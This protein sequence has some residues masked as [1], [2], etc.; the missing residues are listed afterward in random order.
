MHDL[1]PIT[2]SLLALCLLLCLMAGT[3]THADNL[4]LNGDDLHTPDALAYRVDESGTLTIEDIMR[5]PTSAFTPQPDHRLPS[6]RPVWYRL[7][8]PDNSGP[9]QNLYLDLGSFHFN[10]ATLFYVEDGQLVRQQTGLDITSPYG[11]DENSIYLSPAPLYHAAPFGFCMRTL[12]L[13]GTVVM[14]ERFDPVKALSCIDTYGVTH[15][16]WVPTMFVRM[17]KLDPAER[18]AFD[19]SSHR[20][21]MHAAAPCPVAV[22]QQML[23]WGGPIIWE[24]YAGTERNGSTLIGPEEWLAHPG[25]V[26]QAQPPFEALIIGDDGNELPPGQE[27]RLYFHDTTGRGIIYAN[28]PEKT[29]AAHIAPGTFTLGDVGYVDEEGYIFITDRA[30]D[31]IVSGGVNI[32][33]AEIEA[34]LIA[35]EGIEDVAVIGVPHEDMGEAVKALI[36][37]KAASNPPESGELDRFCRARLAAYKCPRTYDI[38]ESVGRNAMGKI[39][40]KELRRPYWPTDR[41]IG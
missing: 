41:T 15:S 26:G 5:L 25:S 7:S 14:M 20:C 29:R 31:M 19:L 39:S 21:A 12:C 30:S 13:G 24:Y 11:F 9:G 36:V 17:L 35:H 18:D 16:Q 8:V 4:L 37:P 3:G 27:G 33:P 2:R 32:Y 34:V 23:D 22:T 6:Q 1:T 10:E 40:K 28:D 38:V